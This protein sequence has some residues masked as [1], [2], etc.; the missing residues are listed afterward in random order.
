[1]KKHEMEGMKT[2]SILVTF[3][4]LHWA[5]CL[6][7][8]LGVGN[9]ARAGSIQL[10]DVSPNPLVVGQ[11]FTITVTASLDVTQGVAVLDFN[12]GTSLPLEV[13]LAGRGTM[14][15]SAAPDRTCCSAVMAT[16]CSSADRDP[17]CSTAGQGTTS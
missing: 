17:T 13:A 1:M 6:A 4:K 16:M 5:V 11:N 9:A 2:E 12:P 7:A 3:R 10:I 15:S 14:F 8:W